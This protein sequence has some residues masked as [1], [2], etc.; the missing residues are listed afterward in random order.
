M[1][2]AHIVAIIEFDAPVGLLSDEI[3]LI[4][5]EESIMRFGVN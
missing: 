5:D 2:D 3:V 1:K 4:V